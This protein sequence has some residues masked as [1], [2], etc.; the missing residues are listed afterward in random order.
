MCVYIIYEKILENQI[1]ESGDKMENAKEGTKK[2]TLRWY[3]Q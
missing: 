1:E 3:V 2:E